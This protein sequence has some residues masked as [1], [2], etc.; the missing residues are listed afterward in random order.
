MDRTEQARHVRALVDELENGAV[1]VATYTVTHRCP[2]CP[3][4]FTGSRKRRELLRHYVACHQESLLV[5]WGRYVPAD[6]GKIDIETADRMAGEF[7]KV[8]WQP[9][10]REMLRD[11]YDT[12]AAARSHVDDRLLGV[13]FER[14]DGFWL[15]TQILPD[16]LLAVLDERGG[17]LEA[18][19]VAVTSIR[20]QLATALSALA[21]PDPTPVAPPKP[22]AKPSVPRAPRAKPKV[23]RAPVA[24]KTPKPRNGGGLEA[25]HE[26]ITEITMDEVEWLSREWG[27]EIPRELAPKFVHLMTGGLTKKYRFRNK[28]AYKRIFGRSINRVA[29]WLNDRRYAADVLPSAPKGTPSPLLAAI[30]SL[31]EHLE[32]LVPRPKDSTIETVCDGGVPARWVEFACRV[33]GKTAERH[34]SRPTT[35]PRTCTRCWEKAGKEKTKEKK[36]EIDR[37]ITMTC[38][39]CN[40]DYASNDASPLWASR[41]CHTCRCMVTTRAR[42]MTPAE[43]A[44]LL[45]FMHQYGRLP[46][47]PREAP[48]TRCDGGQPTSMSQSEI[49]REARARGLRSDDLLLLARKNSPRWMTPS[50]RAAAEF[51][52]NVWVAYAT[53]TG[54]QAVHVRG[55]H[56]F[57][58][59][60]PGLP[61]PNGG[62]YENTLHDWGVLNEALKAT[63]YLELIPMSAIVDNRSP[64]QTYVSYPRDELRLPTID[65]LIETVAWSLQDDCRASWA[66]WARRGESVVVFSEKT[67]ISYVL[68]PIC[69]RLGAAYC[70]GQ[71]QA[72]LTAVGRMLSWA[73]IHEQTCRVLV[74][75]DWD[76]AGA[77]MPTAI[78][79]KLAH[80]VER[81]GGAATVE[82]VCLTEAQVDHYHLPPMPTRSS[83]PQSRVWRA[84]HGGRDARVE[85]DA[86]EALHPGALEH[87]VRGAVY[88]SVD[89]VAE[90]R[91]DAA[92]TRVVEAVRERARELAEGL[93]G[94]L[95]DLVTDLEVTL[96]EAV[97]DHRPDLD[98][99]AGYDTA[100]VLYDSAQPW[101][102]NIRRKHEHLGNDA[103][104]AALED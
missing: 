3:K 56:Y 88:E 77:S 31:E 28:S 91:I 62:P 57:A 71:G 47:M 61:K 23:D 65:A 25:F 102:A 15:G 53:A 52:R 96:L 78:A 46:G 103:I 89:L 100:D 40:D 75:S 81:N 36:E 30:E 54:R 84:R 2:D 4:T 33:C 21:Q 86:L 76:A 51:G 93:R 59:N 69:R 37:W 42:E 79:A 20:I 18:L 32:A 66:T 68:E 44:D 29:L 72:T 43:V 90:T 14:W 94:Q 87:L 19:E 60:P 83:D 6:A 34:D 95:A 7:G 11:Y 58:C 39:Y 12:R 73:R 98:Y 38:P 35:A 101:L 104:V 74:V 48:S 16:Q 22:K 9:L 55:L 49:K 50:K 64:P 13:G 5:R 1:A 82:Q 70:P 27:A 45:D 97:R 92:N 99:D 26:W 67:T 10:V 63:R 80:L 24:V 17:E 85:L 41:R 8:S